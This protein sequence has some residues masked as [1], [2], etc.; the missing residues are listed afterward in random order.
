MA[1]N[2]WN[3]ACA[4]ALAELRTMEALNPIPSDTD[5]QV[6]VGLG[7][8]TDTLGQYVRQGR[9]GHTVALAAMCNAAT[10]AIRQLDKLG[11]TVNWDHLHSLLC[12]KQHDYG[13]QNIDNFGMVGVAVRLCDKIARAANLKD[14][15]NSV[16]DETIVDTYVDIVGYAVIAIMLDSETFYLKLRESDYV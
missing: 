7:I 11:F 16:Q 6:G 2:T 1:P 14:R 12:R 5:A 9:S 3:E 13:H 10:L 8:I 4:E 15:G